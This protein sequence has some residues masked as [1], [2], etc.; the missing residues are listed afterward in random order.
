MLNNNKE[1]MY[2]TLEELEAHKGKYFIGH[3]D[4]V[5]SEITR[6]EF[7][8]HLKENEYDTDWETTDKGVMR[9]MYCDGYI[10]LYVFKRKR[11]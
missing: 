2:N 10:L 4:D 11:Q 8:T 5:F 1:N 6:E 7:Y 3:V 9:Y